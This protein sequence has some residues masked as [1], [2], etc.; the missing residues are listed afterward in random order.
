MKAAGHADPYAVRNKPEP[1]KGGRSFRLWPILTAVAGVAV[2]VVGILILSKMNVFQASESSDA[3]AATTTVP[4]TVALEGLPRAELERHFSELDEVLHKDLTLTLTP[5][6]VEAG[7][8]EEPLVLTLS[9][10][11]SG[12]GLDLQRL[13]SDL[14]AGVGQ[15]RGDS[16]LLDPRNYLVW[17]EETLRNRLN[18]FAA[19]YGTEFA[20]ASDE[21]GAVE[22]GD[23]NAE[24]V[25][26]EKVLLVRSGVIGRGFTAENLYE[27]VRD[28]W[29]LALIAEDPEAAL[30]SAMSYEF[31]VPE[32]VDVDQLYERYCKDAVEPQLEKTTGNVTEG[33]DGYA[34]DREALTAA[35]ETLA[36]G[37][38]LRVGIFATHP[39]LTAKELRKTLFKDVIAEA[40]TRHTAI[41]NRTNNLKLACKEI[42]GTILMPGEEFSFNKT[43]GQRTEEKGYKEAIAYV[44]GGESKPEVGGG[45]C[46]VASSIYY[47]VLQADLETTQRQPHM[48]KVDYVPIGMDATIYWGSLD[49]RFKN[50]SPYPIKIEASVSGG[51]VHI[52]LLG[53]EWKD[54][55]VELSSEILETTEPETVEKEVPNDGTYKN[56]EVITTAYTGYKVATYRTTRSKST[57]KKIETTQIA[58]SRYKKRD[59]VIAKVVG[60]PTN[61]T[62]TN[63][64]QK[65][66]EKPTQKPTEKPTN[67]PPSSSETNPP[68]SSSETN[69]PPSSS[70]TNPPPSSSETNP[71]PSSSETNPP[72]SSS[73]TNPP[74]PSSNEGGGEEP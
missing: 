60:A 53:T 35:L 4:S 49:Y 15:E 66:T 25:K 27:S 72:P 71:P 23:A 68:P 7:H 14:D 29:Q 30:D 45:I 6:P 34:F 42:D 48:Y 12:A 73:E 52:K 40:H 13:K 10:A 21:L 43:V 57:G 70:E 36:P 58:I 44:S 9:Q 64:T 16:Y 37:E 18:A 24:G 5:D 38:E 8:S 56:G 39:Q 74:P 51:K 65:P 26:P 31:R 46:Q 19:E 11:D 33:E 55:T 28:A 3:L 1:A 47:A 63:P 69:P 32:P 20:P 62:P 2:I 50:T 67:P 61:P 41:A 17:N 22:D 54:Y 59:K